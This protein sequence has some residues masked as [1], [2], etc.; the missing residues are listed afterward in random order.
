MRSVL[1]QLKAR[2]I[3]SAVYKTMRLPGSLYMGFNKP[4]K[5]ATLSA[6]NI[7]MEI[8]LSPKVRHNNLPGPWHSSF[9]FTL[10]N[11]R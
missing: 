8:I 6:S 3:Q 10:L 11:N 7:L 2:T 9:T 4:H 1:K 5:K